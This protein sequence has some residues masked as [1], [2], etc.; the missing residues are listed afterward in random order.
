MCHRMSL[1]FFILAA[2]SWSD[3]GFLVPVAVVLFFGAIAW[4]STR[5]RAARVD[6]RA[7]QQAQRHNSRLEAQARDDINELMV[8]LEEL[9]REICGRIDTRF[10]KLEHVLAEADEK[11]RALAPILRQLEAA[12]GGQTPPDSGQ[13]PPGDPLHEEIHDR[14]AAGARVVDVAKEKGLAAG[15]VELILALE[16]SRREAARLPGLPDG[17]PAPAKGAN[18]DEKA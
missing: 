15:E 16:R 2:G 10:A 12:P 5:R 4:G 11:L 1:A 3:P 13:P 9:S 8:R 14:V 6:G 18:L 17:P 7:G